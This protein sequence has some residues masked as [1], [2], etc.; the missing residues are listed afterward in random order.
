[1]SDLNIVGLVVEYNPFHNGHLYHLQRS[2]AECGAEFAVCAMSGNFLQRGE[3]AVVDKWTRAAMAI[4]GGADVVLE[5]PVAFAAHSAEY[6]AAGAVGLLSAAG[7]V[8]H[9]SFGSESGDLTALQSL[10][11]LLAEEPEPLAT[12]IRKEMAA[13]VSYP[14]AR[15]KAIARYL[16]DTA[17]IAGLTPEKACEILARPNNILSVEYLKALHAT[18]S[19]LR[20]VT[21]TRVKA[22]YHNPHF[23]PDNIASATAIRRTL[24]E[25][26]GTAEAAM[27]AAAPFIPPAAREILAKAFRRGRAPIS[28]E[29]LAPVL[30]AILRRADAATLAT[31]AG[32]GEG[33]ENRLLAAAR[34]AATIQEFLT[35]V[36]TKRYPWTRLQRIL[37][38]ILL[39][40]TADDAA[41]FR[42]AGPQYLRVLAF[43][44]RGRMLLRRMR[45]EATIPVLHRPARYFGTGTN[46]GE[47]ML[48]LDILA[49][50]L[51][52]LALPD[53]AARR[54]NLDFTHRANSPL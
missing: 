30:L 42:A 3:P 8:T 53:P 43:S 32:I 51:Y 50:D 13:G 9:L 15:A 11:R 44:P 10:S 18:A 33:L 14:A 1:M 23:G 48:R 40:Y 54:G 22:D 41:A 52:T 47:R 26:D 27:T 2:K 17:P 37:V 19:P 16:R 20:P 31:V 29:S 6:F 4:T 21:V 38:H 45:E 7:I 12:Q 25:K 5:L 24:L 28:W 39:N 49:T 35:A 34:Q 36:K 46:V